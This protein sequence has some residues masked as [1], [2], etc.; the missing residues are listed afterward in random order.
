MTD[1]PLLMKP[2]MVRAVLD[3]SKLQTRRVINP[4]PSWLDGAWFWKSPNYDNGAG[5]NYFHTTRIEGVMAPWVK[6]MRYK[7]GDRIYLREAWKALAT[8]DFVAPRDM[9]PTTQI[10][11]LADGEER[12]PDGWKAGKYGRHRQAMHMPRWASRATLFVEDVRI[13]Q[14]Q[15]ITPKD[16]VDEGLQTESLHYAGLVYQYRD[17]AT[18]QLIESPNAQK[19]F[20]HLWDGINEPRGFGWVNNPWVVAVTFRAEETNIDEIGGDLEAE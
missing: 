15:S 8:R 4:T 6:A 3:G 16:C 7:V 9:P 12:A 17:E 10:L 19:V 2:D 20:R 13:Q 5:S 1:H 18:G 14:I 11:Y